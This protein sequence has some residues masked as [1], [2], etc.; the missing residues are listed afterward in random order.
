MEGRLV[1]LDTHVA[2]TVM[3]RMLR[4]GSAEE[5][6]TRLAPRPSGQESLPARIPAGNDHTAAGLDKRRQSLAELG[7]ATGQLAGKG[8]EIAPEALSGNIE[9]LVGFARIPVGV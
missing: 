5:L 7:I 1:P 2:H 6:A 3:S 4:E 9:N 8:E